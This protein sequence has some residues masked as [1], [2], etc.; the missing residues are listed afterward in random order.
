MLFA[1]AKRKKTRT[2]GRLYLYTQMEVVRNGT[3]LSRLF[4]FLGAFP[5]QCM[6]NENGCEMGTGS[7]CLTNP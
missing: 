4:V 5:H 3:L 1:Q 7:H 2:V 6:D